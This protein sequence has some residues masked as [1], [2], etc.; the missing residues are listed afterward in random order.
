MSG[1]PFAYKTTNI[2]RLGLEACDDV[3]QCGVVADNPD[4]LI[5]YLD[6]RDD[7]VPQRGVTA[8]V[9]HHPR[10]TYRVGDYSGR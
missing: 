9:D 2:S 6:P 8:N 3:P 7:P 1:A 5:V 10:G 4:I